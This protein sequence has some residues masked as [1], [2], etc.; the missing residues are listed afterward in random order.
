[1]GAFPASASMRSACLI[2][3]PT[4]PPNPNPTN[5]RILRGYTS[6][7]G[8]VSVVEVCYPDCTNYEGRKIL[9]FEANISRV[10]SRTQLDPHFCED[11]FSPIARFE[12]T[13]RGWVHACSYAASLDE[14]LS[15]A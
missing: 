14:K 13:E 7:N 4:P 1:M 15:K 10:I 3:K 6:L 5:F 12:P 9:V 8:K 11:H 2:G